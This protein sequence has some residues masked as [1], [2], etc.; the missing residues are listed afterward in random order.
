[1]PKLKQTE[2]AI[3]ELIRKAVMD[4]MLSMGERERPIMPKVESWE[5][6]KSLLEAYEK[7]LEEVDYHNTHLLVSGLR[8]ILES[9]GMLSN[10]DLGRL[11]EGA[12]AI[13]EIYEFV[14]RNPWFLEGI[15]R[16]GD[17]EKYS[18]HLKK[19]AAYLEV[20]DEFRGVAENLARSFVERA[21]K[22]GA[23]AHDKR[24]VLDR[25]L[26]SVNAQASYWAKVESVLRRHAGEER[27]EPHRIAESLA[28]LVP[29]AW[30]RA[31]ER[32]IVIR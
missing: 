19:R 10:E 25:L 30:N 8:K 3:E 17:I 12:G 21:A 11:A 13:R 20:P 2:V 26:R 29:G 1:M 4:A 7:T 5:A 32:K 27:I 18:A 23:G 15:L 24:E 9:K 31:I 6:L 22:E 16:G 28:E 14:Q